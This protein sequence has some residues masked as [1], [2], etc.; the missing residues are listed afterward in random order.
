M[1]M[2]HDSKKYSETQERPIQS[3]EPLRLIYKRDLLCRACE[4]KLEINL[5]KP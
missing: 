1:L 2:S 3:K 5:K 4:K